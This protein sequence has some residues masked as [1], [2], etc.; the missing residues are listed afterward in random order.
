MTMEAKFRERER[1]EDDLLL[2]L[3]VKNRAMSQ[4]MWVPLEAR[5]RPGNR[6]SSGASTRNAAQSGPV[7]CR[8]VR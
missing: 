6:F 3:K 5:E 7:T 2:A 4:G 8:T 1:F